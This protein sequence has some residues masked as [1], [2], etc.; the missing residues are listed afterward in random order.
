MENTAIVTLD[1][2]GSFK[3]YSF[4]ARDTTLIFYELLSILSD[5]EEAEH[6]AKWC[7]NARK[8]QICCSLNGAAYI[9]IM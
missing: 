8:G 7:L 4:L 5:Y 2:Y 3:K 1:W 9:E 6:M